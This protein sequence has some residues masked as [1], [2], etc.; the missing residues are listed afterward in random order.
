[1]EITLLI[2]RAKDDVFLGKVSRFAQAA[3]KDL[4]VELL[5]SYADGNHG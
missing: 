4:G 5:V 2:T 3:A 1:L